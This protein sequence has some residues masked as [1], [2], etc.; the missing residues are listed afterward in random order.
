M[1]DATPPGAASAAAAAPVAPGA[2]R[3]AAPRPK[4]PGAAPTYALTAAAF[5]IVLTLL[6]W[7]VRA[8]KD[9]AIGPAKPAAATAP[10]KRVV[11]VK[12]IERKVIVEEAA[13]ATAPAAAAPAPAGA[14]SAPAAPA[15]AAAAP[16]PAPAA[17][18]P[19]LA[20]RSS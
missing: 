2:A 15:P 12:R 5:L 11:V 1:T 4:R 8:G 19:V 18:A 9:P 20:T 17:P 10:K 7:Q 16:A 6:A 14:P 13:P 3:A